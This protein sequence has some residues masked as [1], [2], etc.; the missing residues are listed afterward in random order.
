[1]FHASLEFVPLAFAA[2]L[3]LLN[4]LGSALIVMNIVGD[5][6]PEIYRRLAMR[7]ARNMLIFIALIELLGAAILHFFGISLPVLQVAGGLTLAMMGWT[8]LNAHDAPATDAPTARHGVDSVL[9]Q[10]FYPLTFP[11]TVGP[12]VIVVVLTLSADASGKEWETTLVSHLAIFFAAMLL[13]VLVFLSYAYAPRLQ[14]MI[15]SHVA[16]G[17]QRLISFILLCIGAQIAWGGI[18]TLLRSLPMTT[19]G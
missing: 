14:R 13:A 9:D 3:P 19:A 2:L 5:E 17:V 12:G 8:M 6:P 7:I 10:A 4:P 15:P 18:A 11:V 1:M 16:S